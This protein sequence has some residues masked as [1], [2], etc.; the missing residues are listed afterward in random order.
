MIR[1]TI[2]CLAFGCLGFNLHADDS[3][4]DQVRSVLAKQAKAWND[5]D[6]DK[7]MSDY[8][9]S[10]KLTFSSGGKTTRGWQSTYDRFKKKYKT[11]DD[12]GKLEFK[13]LEVTELVDSALVLGRWHVKRK[14][15]EFGGNFTLLFRKI[16]KRWLIVHDHTSLLPAEK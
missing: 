1:R 6:I 3:I 16:E 14:S 5:G 11:A 7:F 2:F 9:K 8:W 4:S 12:M 15:D 10:E 13:D